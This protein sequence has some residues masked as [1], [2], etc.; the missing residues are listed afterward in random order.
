MGEAFAGKTVG[1]KALVWGALAQ[2]IPDID[3]IAGFYLDTTDNLLAHRGFTHSIL[4]GLIIT[5]LMAFT[6]EYFHRPHNISLKR[7]MGFFAA[8]VLG[9]IFFDA[10]NN[11]GVA[12]FEPF[13]HSRI[14]FNTV[15]VADPFFSISVFI[16]CIALMVLPK[17]SIRRKFW[18][19]FGLAATAVYMGY[20]L[21]NKFKIDHDVKEA[22][23][24]QG[25]AYNMYFTTPAPLQNWLWF[26]VAGDKEGFHVG[27]HSVYDRDKK[28]TL[29]YFPRN[30]HLLKPYEKD[31]DLMNL[32]R[33]SQGFYTAEM[34][35]DTLVFNDLRFGQ[36]VGWFDTK[37]KFAFHYY[38]L[39]P[40]SNELVVQRGRFARWSPVIA[41]S[42]LRRII[43][44]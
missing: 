37:G 23:K 24:E 41:E 11:Y 22:L 25:I 4:F 5:P 42:L 2:S 1:R 39:D 34:Y 35:S 43:G 32:K 15:Y 20:S 12:W 13:D 38:L 33:F 14:S 29:T 3:F 7:W 21:I 6:A 19:K 16:A 8:V 18:W 9:H 28:I 17:F 30:E 44:N 36:E 26:V 10:F 40:G 31:K 27:Y